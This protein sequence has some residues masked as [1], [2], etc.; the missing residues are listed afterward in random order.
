MDSFKFF[1]KLSTKVFELRL[2]DD[3]LYKTQPCCFYN[4]SLSKTYETNFQL[5][6]FQ[7]YILKGLRK[8][9]DY[10]GKFRVNWR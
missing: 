8:R 7:N 6:S 1:Y 9:R 4:I 2:S 3:Y 5:F 10:G